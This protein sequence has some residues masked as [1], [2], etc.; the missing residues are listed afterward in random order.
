MF[1]QVNRKRRTASP[2]CLLPACTQPEIQ[3]SAKIKK[4]GETKKIQTYR[5]TVKQTDTHTDTQTDSQTDRHTYRHTLP[6]QWFCG[7]ARFPTSAVHSDL[8]TRVCTPSSSG[9]SRCRPSLGT[10]CGSSHLQSWAPR[11]PRRA[12]RD[13]SR[14]RSM[15]GTRATRSRDAA[16]RR[17]LYDARPPRHHHSLKIDRH[18]GN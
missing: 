7:C 12:P 16:C 15:L 1:R 14:A 11:A 9:R 3:C 2:T 13:L 10:V 18:M 8:R 6:V 17:R 5:P 4:H